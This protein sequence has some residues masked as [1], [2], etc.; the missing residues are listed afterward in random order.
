VVDVEGSPIR[1]GSEVQLCRCG[2]SANK[3]FC[4]GSHGPAGFEG[5]GDLPPD[6]DA[7]TEALPPGPLEIKV[8][9]NGPLICNGPV[10]I[11]DQNGVETVRSKVSFCRCGATQNGPFCDGS[12]RDHGFEG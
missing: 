7:S 10:T 1:K 5:T 6:S 12:H 11:T 4:D 8:V 3:P 2:H 9:P